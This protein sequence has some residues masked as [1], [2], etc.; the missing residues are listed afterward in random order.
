MKKFLLVL[1]VCFIAFGQVL[2]QS[3]TIS[4]T[5]RNAAD[6]EPIIGASVQVKGTSKGTITDIDGKFSLSVAPNSVLVVSFIGM[7]TQEV[8]AKDGVVVNLSE[9]TEVLDEVMVI[10][11]GTATRAQFVGSAKEVKGDDLT[12]QARS[13]VTNALQGKMAGVQVV[14]GSGQPGQGATIRIRG[15]GS[16]N[17]GTTP[18]YIVDGAP[19]EG[20]INSISSYDIA[21]ITVLKDAAATAIYG[22]RGA[23]G[24]VLIT[25]KSGSTNTKFEVNVDAKWGTNQREIPNYNVMRD[26][27]MYMETAYKALYNTIIYN[28]GT[29]TEAYDYADSRLFSN[30]SG[31][32]G[33]KVYNVPE[34]ELL[35]GRNFK[36]NPHATLG[37]ND[38]Q[39]YY[40]PDNWE[41]NALNTNNLRH[42]YNININGGNADTQY[43][44][45]AGYLSDPG[46]IAGSSFERYTIRGRVDSQV[47]KWLK[48]GGAFAYAHTNTNSPSDQGKWGSTGNLFFIMNHVAPIYPYYTRDA[49]GNIRKDANG[50]TVY[51]TG[52]NTNQQRTG[53]GAPLGNPAINLN[54]DKQQTVADNF[55][56]NMYLTITPVEG[57]NITAR[58]S[59]TAINRRYQALSN[60]WYSAVT[61][62]GAVGIQSSR[63]FSL[64][65]QYMI[66]YKRRFAQEHNLEL[67]A[68]WEEYWVRSQS[69]S[70]SNDHLFNP[71]IAELGNAF[72]EEPTV[73]NVGSGTLDFKTAGLF[74][75]VQ[76]DL[77]DRYFLNATYR[78]EGS[79]NFAPK[80][81]WGHFGSVGVAW[82]INRE[83]FMDSADWLDELKLKASWGT[84]GNDQ[85]GTLPYMDFYSISY[86]AETGEFSKTL[87]D[88]SGETPGYKGNPD[89]TW[90]KQ[91]L[92]NV[93]LEF[94]FLKNRLGGSAEYF[95][96]TNKDMLFT[97]TMPASAGYRYISRNVGTVANNGLELELYG[98][99]V[100]TRNIEWEINANLT[101]IKSK[102]VSLPDVY[103]DKGWVMS[104]CIIREG[105]S[106]VEGYMP[107]YA[108]VDQTTGR[109]LYY[110]NPDAE[111]AAG[112]YDKS[113]W[114]TTTE[115]ADAQQADLG[116][117]A[118][119]CYGGF[120][121]TFKAYGI[122]LSISCAYQFGGKSYDGMYQELMHGG[123]QNGCN[124]HMDILNA[125]TPENT[126]TNVPRLSA[127]SVDDW[128][129]QT[130]DRWLVSSDYLSLNN[131]TLGYTLPKKWTKKA[132]IEKVRIYF[133]GDNLALLS[134]RKGFDPRQGQNTSGVGMRI[135]TNSGN[136][137]YSQLRTL[138]GGI[139]VTF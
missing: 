137:V 133:Q 128:D 84:Q 63:I 77:M 108:G 83:G 90:E 56:G 45:S 131:I 129:Q 117:L 60:P 107:M 57:L 32:V 52:N 46:I 42:E 95:N 120:G 135:S 27:A 72:G 76:Y 124:W 6:D 9:D 109:A 82:L 35:I 110:V 69:L 112:N 61:S 12:N 39:Y 88:Y 1:S 89:L 121:T 3:Q 134:A 25:T 125:W 30:P 68:G 54:I 101:Y 98:V 93:G 99:L 50:Y 115:Y 100:K 85:I 26:P 40:T 16:I 91:M 14:N 17:G 75:R 106:L 74:A 118:V 20:S 103:K 122:D 81:R 70:A 22:A 34:G 80:N 24:V 58:V 111:R 2:A 66:S 36:L 96:R 19:F 113:T 65:Q 28:G 87:V 102:V 78:F 51:D 44:L 104:S 48:V 97:L 126:N 127:L 13:N 53:T 116:D 23:N 123:A 119:K 55:Q 64:D 7:S 138:S 59:P 37:Y 15:I 18:L 114:A 11:Y 79:S 5:V 29:P 130:C 41:A 67:L 94:D 105:G 47:K 31:G 62:K 86:N 92:S 10:G 73:N 33:Y 132:Q 49:E 71:F 8:A 21:S 139:S 4:G 43:F 38:G 136:Y